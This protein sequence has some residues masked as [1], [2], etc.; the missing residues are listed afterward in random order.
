MALQAP[1]HPPVVE[2]SVRSGED[3]AH[4]SYVVI[5]I[6]VMAALLVAGFLLGRQFAPA[7]APS[8][9]APATAAAPA[10]APAPRAAPLRETVPHSLL[11]PLWPKAVTAPSSRVRESV[12]HS[13]LAP[14]WGES[15]AY[16]PNANAREG[17]AVAAAGGGLQSGYGDSAT[18]ARHFGHDSA[19]IRPPS[20]W[21]P[22]PR[23]HA[24]LG[25]V[26]R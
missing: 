17:R 18:L 13:L 22:G 21:G 14:L 25:P 19:A 24:R 10:P 26:W 12:P 4:L 2:R 8:A 7:S 3:R 11:A 1:H 20:G 15:A 9:A 6:V 5:S 23:S 16:E